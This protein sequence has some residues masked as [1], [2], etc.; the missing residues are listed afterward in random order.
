MIIFTL[1]LGCL[2]FTFD[3]LVKPLSLVLTII[4]LLG[5]YSINQLES[6]NEN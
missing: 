2:M 3:S 4:A 6:R 5:I 1:I